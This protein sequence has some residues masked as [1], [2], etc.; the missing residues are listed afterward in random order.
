VPEE[1]REDGESERGEYAGAKVERRGVARVGFRAAGRSRARLR[2]A[3][4]DGEG[5]E[6]HEPEE[7]VVHVVA[8]VPE[9][10]AGA[11][12]ARGEAGD[13]DEEEDEHRSVHPLRDA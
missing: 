13:A 9:T 8:E 12:V 10:Q 1:A 3:P 7:G 5:L 11:H 6:P 2:K 4:E